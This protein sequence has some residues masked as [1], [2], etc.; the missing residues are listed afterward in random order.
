MPSDDN[1]QA[2]ANS[3]DIP[4][5]Q[6]ILQPNQISPAARSLLEHYS[7]IPASAIDA[8]ATQIR[9]KAWSI[10]PYPCIGQWRFLDLSISQQ[11]AYGRVLDL[12]K[13]GQDSGDAK[14]LLDL[15]CCFAQDI[16]KLIYDGAP[17]GNLYGCD[18][19]AEFLELGFDLFADRGR[20]GAHFFVADV[21]AD[22]DGSGKSGGGGLV[23]LAGK[24]DVVY[25]ASFLH[26]FSWEDQVRIAKRIIRI[27]KPSRGSLVFG[28]QT[29]SVRGRE[30]LNK[31]HGVRGTEKIWR[32]DVESFRKLWHV[33]GEE[34][35]S[36]WETWAELYE[37]AHTSSHWA[38]EGVRMLRFEVKRV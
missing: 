23:A 8:H 37:T 29:G 5:Y 22:N 1:H 2:P 32:H 36:K 24:V 26:I 7:R 9:D 13:E 21:L 25:A 28:R 31:A 11:P 19:K 17:A 33:A 3:N 10:F 15:G 6:P 27:L 34:T 38:E 14:L 20:C 4:W 35:G 30:E 18:L 16:R 12:L